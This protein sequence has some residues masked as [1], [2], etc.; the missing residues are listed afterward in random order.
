M[1]I[2][3][4]KLIHKLPKLNKSDL[5]KI[6]D[7]SINHFENN[8]IPHKEEL[9]ANDLTE[10]PVVTPEIIIEWARNTVLYSVRKYKKNIINELSNHYDDGKGKFLNYLNNNISSISE[11]IT[12]L[13]M[14]ENMFKKVNDNFNKYKSGQCEINNE[15]VA[16]FIPLFKVLVLGIFNYNDINN[17]Y[18]NVIKNIVYILKEEF[19]EYSEENVRFVF[20]NYVNL[21]DTF[22]TNSLDKLKDKFID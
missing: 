11:N 6:S 13:N 19:N 1:R 9:T 20:M 22:V 7:E 17:I 21:K 15:D 3:Y 14:I 10:M 12:I 8:I 2:S 16:C 4:D 18:L 5:N